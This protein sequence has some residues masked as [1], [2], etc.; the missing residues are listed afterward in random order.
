MKIDRLIQ[1]ALLLIAVTHLLELDCDS[2]GT[3]LS[4]PV[5]LELCHP[6]YPMQTGCLY[7]QQTQG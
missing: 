5:K 4:Q 7:S 3:A 2:I 6:G 1:C